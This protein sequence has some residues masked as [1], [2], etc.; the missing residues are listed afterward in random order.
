MSFEPL[1]TPIDH[2]L[3]S[4]ERSPGI[5]SV[6]GADSERELQE[7]RGYGLGGAFVVYKGIKLIEPKV[8][9]K[10][11]TVDDWNDWHEWRPVLSRPPTGRRPQALDIWHPILED[12]GVTSVLVKKVGQPVPSDD[13][14]WTITIDFKEY[15]RPQRALATADGSSTERLTPGELAILAQQ[16]QNENLTRQRDALAGS[17]Q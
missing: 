1:T 4:G 12:Q 8:T 6:T 2:I 11:V 14:S 7:R 15:R 3:L 5:A 13:G 9:L 16:N 10:L 17:V